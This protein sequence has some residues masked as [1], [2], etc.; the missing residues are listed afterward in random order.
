A[1]AVGTPSSPPISTSYAEIE[2]ALRA[3]GKQSF[4]TEY[5]L[6][7]SSQSWFAPPCGFTEPVVRASRSVFER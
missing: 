6:C 2:S 4:S 5:A 1:L 3:S 7:G